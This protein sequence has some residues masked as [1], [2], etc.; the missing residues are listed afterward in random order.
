MTGRL[1]RPTAALLPGISRDKIQLPDF[2]GRTL[3]PTINLIRLV[4]PKS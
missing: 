2:A 1:I 4:I 3:F